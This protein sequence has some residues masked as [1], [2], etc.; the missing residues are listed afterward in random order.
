[1]KDFQATLDAVVSEGGSQGV[2]SDRPS[3]N[4]FQAMLEA[5][6][7]EPLPQ[8]ALATPATGVTKSG[9]KRLPDL[10]TPSQRQIF[11]VATTPPPVEP[12]RQ[13]ELAAER[14]DEQRRKKVKGS[15]ASPGGAKQQKVKDEG[16]GR[17]AQGFQLMGLWETP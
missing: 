15:K 7:S 11:E 12:A 8:G 4:D 5:V 16:E 2:L 3:M 10:M 6:I 1:M 9:E 13:R 14:R 17:E